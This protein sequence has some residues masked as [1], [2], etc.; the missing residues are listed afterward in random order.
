[1][2]SGNVNFQKNAPE[3]RKPKNFVY[4]FGSREEAGTSI[5]TGLVVEPGDDETVYE[6]NY[7]AERLRRKDICNELYPDV[8]EVEWER[9]GCKC[10]RMPMCGCYEPE[11]FKELVEGEVG[12]EGA[13]GL[14]P[15]Y[16]DEVV[17]GELD[18]ACAEAHSRVHMQY[19]LTPH[20]FTDW[21]GKFH[22]M[23]D[24]VRM[25]LAMD[26]PDV[27]GKHPVHFTGIL[28]RPFEGDWLG[29][30]DG[31]GQYEIFE[32]I[33]Q[34]E[35]GHVRARA[36][37]GVNGV[38]YDLLVKPDRLGIRLVHRNENQFAWTLVS[39]APNRVARVLPNLCSA[40][41]P[42]PFLC[43]HKFINTQ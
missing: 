10:R 15:R 35:A 2:E 34:P 33:F 30:Q 41:T 9:D 43:P 12:D 32:Q 1:M 24:D 13:R 37:R 19:G 18:L 8:D 42:Y 4:S 38:S 20:S 5:R 31:F 29:P 25:F 36:R 40:C 23:V 21:R 22:S 39:H 17:R 14:V 16:V 28:E 26:V 3:K 7:E 27:F 11:R 6:A